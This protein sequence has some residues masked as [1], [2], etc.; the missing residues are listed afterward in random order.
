LCSNDLRLQRRDIRCQQGWAFGYE[1]LNDDDNLRSDPL[2]ASVVGKNDPTG[3][4]PEHRRDQG[5]AFA[6][7]STFGRIELTQVGADSEDRGRDGRAGSS[8]T[9]G[10]RAARNRIASRSVDDLGVQRR[11]IGLSK[12]QGLIGIVGIAGGRI[13]LTVGVDAPGELTTS[14]KVTLMPISGIGLAFL[15]P[16]LYLGGNSRR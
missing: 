14:R 12:R 11:G 6:A 7:K 8:R 9:A 16:S 3:K 1:V 4:P 2:L 5:K 15:L 10:C 13:G